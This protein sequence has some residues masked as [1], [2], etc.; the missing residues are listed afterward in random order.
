MTTVWLLLRA[1]LRHRWR[2]LLGL[3]LILG[4]AG[5]VVIT[6]AAGARRTATAYPRLLAWA[7][8]TQVTVIVTNSESVLKSPPGQP[9][10]Q[11]FTAGGRAAEAVRRQY[12]AALGRLPGVASVSLATEYNM[13]LPAAG[14]AGPD[15]GV[16]VFASRDGSLGVSGDRVKIT[17]G[18]MFGSAAAGA[19]VIDQ[20][21]ASRLGL[22]PGGTLRLLGIRKDSSGTANL[23]LA[24][25]LAFRVTGIGLFDDQVVPATATTA[26]PRV[27]L[28][29]P[30]AATDL[31]VAMTN[32]PEAAVRLRTGA[33]VTAFLHA[34][35]V[36]RARYGIDSGDFA[37][38]TTDDETA[39]TERAI[40]PQALALAVFAALAGLIGLVVTC[41]LLARQLAL[42]AG[43]FPALRAIGATRGRLTVGAL[44]RLLAMTV[45]GAAV[46]VVIAV[47]ASPLMPIGPA[48]LAEPAPGIA[49]DFPVLGA[50]F[51]AVALL[52]V[53][54]LAPSA[55]RAVRRTAR[56]SGTGTGAV[57][58]RAASVAGLFGHAGW[59][60]T[61]TG[62][63]MA[64]EPGRGRTAVPVRTALAGTAIAVGALAAALVFVASLLG[65]VATPARYGQ[66]WDA[67]VDAGYADI[68]ASY[69]ARLL[70][71]V[72]GIAG[73]A[74]GNNGELMVD[75]TSV[76]AIGVDR[77]RGDGPAGGY[78][79]LLSGRPPSGAGQIALGTRT[80]RALGKHVGQTVR[81]QVTWRGGVAGPPAIRTM[82]IT[83][84]AVFP[85]FGL[86]S[87]ASTDLG[88]GAVVATSLL[89]GITANTGC[90]GRQTCYNFLLL[91]L[92]PG[93]SASGTGATLLA[94]A[95]QA[96]CPPGQCTVMT[97]QRPGDIRDYAGI[98]DTPLALG[99]VLALLAVGTL[100]HV[101]LTGVRRRRRDLAVLKTLGLTRRQVQ[102]VVAWNATAL[103]V[104]ALLIGVPLGIV[105]GR[106]AW[107]LFADAAGVAASATID[108]PLVLLVIPATVVLANVIAA[109]PGWAAAR[110][111][112]AVVLRTE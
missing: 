19:A 72:P 29:A 75:G 25:P 42:D 94:R 87:L 32:L 33:S 106:W 26:Q 28:S 9:A 44:G 80:L 76:P 73:Y 95:A 47:V 3:A 65:L 14:G 88:S 108:V 8:A 18:R 93:T 48:R 77:M 111:R 61:S 86:P 10:G 51:A 43:D 41:Q 79:T 78:L 22:R 23:K 92:R 35:D 5:G 85:A 99:A 91:R 70:A 46:A 49:V 84:T 6:A 13:A 53:A 90:T 38:V 36:L 57:A 102:A 55:W 4:L 107:A 64:F 67:K 104:A 20:A 71:G 1:D 96:D 98:R 30:F 62:M 81:V 7:D 50:G 2:A 58:G 103:A 100:A 112:P 101:L 17:A 69:G 66:N 15:T 27:L 63:R 74:M 56:A 40:R 83:G 54:A 82:R 110:L 52:P 89:S 109:W 21:L 39:A 34:V 59:V 68:P 37:T 16:Q 11:Y 31:A 105:A 24:V 45:P 97:D 12:F 60:T